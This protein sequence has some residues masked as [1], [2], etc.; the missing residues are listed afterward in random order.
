MPYNGQGTDA[1]PG[2]PRR[3]R[4]VRRAARVAADREPAT[5]PCDGAAGDTRG[6]RDIRTMV[7]VCINFSATA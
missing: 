5:R 7:R 6:A 2:P 4:V 1:V 3:G